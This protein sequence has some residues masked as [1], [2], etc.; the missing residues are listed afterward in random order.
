MQVTLKSHKKLFPLVPCRELYSPFSLRN[1]G[2]SATLTS[3]TKYLDYPT[4]KTSEIHC[5]SVHFH[6][7]KKSSYCLA[8]F[9]GKAISPRNKTAKKK[10]KINRDTFKIVPKL[11]LNLG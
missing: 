1:V 11:H 9:G 4:T 3:K 6:S 2:V 5:I 7:R 10:K 8:M